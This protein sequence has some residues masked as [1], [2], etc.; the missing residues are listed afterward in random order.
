MSVTA[1]VDLDIPFDVSASSTRRDKHNARLDAC[2]YIGARGHRAQL[3]EYYESSNEHLLGK[4]VRET[5]KQEDHRAADRVAVRM[6][7]LRVQAHTLTEERTMAMSGDGDGGG[8]DGGGVGGKYPPSVEH[9]RVEMERVVQAAH[10]AH[11]YAEEHELLREAPKHVAVRFASAEC[12]NAARTL[13]NDALRYLSSTE[14]GRWLRRQRQNGNNVSGTWLWADGHRHYDTIE[15][16]DG[17]GT[18]KRIEITKAKAE[19]AL[20]LQG[21]WRGKVARRRVERIWDRSAQSDLRAMHKALQRGRRRDQVRIQTH[22]SMWARS[23]LGLLDDPELISSRQGGS[24]PTN[25]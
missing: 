9:R 24:R 22:T 6:H 10:T 20:R 7:A 18:V 16:D 17:P 11:N 5:M 13:G 15:G 19:L 14:S 3:R 12:T 8:D 23:M 1:E 25:R 21:I 4:H 2:F